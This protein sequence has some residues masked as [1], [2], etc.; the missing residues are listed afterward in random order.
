M[1]PKAY[2]S[3]CTIECKSLAENGELIRQYDVTYFMASV[4]P[5]VKNKGFA[6]EP[7]PTFPANDEDKSV[8]K[9]YGVLGLSGLAKRRTFYIGKDGRILKIDT[10]INP[11][12]SAED[13]VENL[14]SWGWAPVEREP[15]PAIRR[16]L[17]RRS[18]ASRLHLRASNSSEDGAAQYRCRGGILAI[19][20][21]DHRPAAY[22]LG[23]G[24][25]SVLSTRALA[26]V[27]NAPQRDDARRN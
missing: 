1:F 10:D 17:H 18:T 15:G 5:L 6:E 27:L 9:A 12:T 23:M 11:P 3:G 20:H 26:S 4:D 7:A 2:T 19:E 8:A 13:M 25:P 14:A 24:S 21:A 16:G 22:R